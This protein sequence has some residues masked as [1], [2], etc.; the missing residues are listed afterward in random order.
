MA[1]PGPT[2]RAEA[3]TPTWAVPEAA[4][5][6]ALVGGFAATW[7]GAMTGVPGVAALLAGAFA[8]FYQAALHR[9]NAHGAAGMAAGAA[10]LGA[11]VGAIGLVLEL[12]PGGAA[13]ALPLAETYVTQAIEPLY[14]ADYAGRPPS[15]AGGPGQ[16]LAAVVVLAVAL[17]SARATRSLVPLL[18]AALVAGW[19]GI[20]GATA[21]AVATPGETH[22]LLSLHSVPPWAL[23]QLVGVVLTASVLS[24]GA[25]V[26]PLA[27]LDRPRRR[28]LAVGAPALLLGLVLQPLIAAPWGAWVSSA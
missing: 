1:E 2:W 23:L 14:R 6:L 21:A 25:P 12:G 15:G 10:I 18:A 20:A 11:L 8:T 3:P 7:A 27:E 13:R 26:F 4:W 28:L 17:A 5:F 22:V 19:L 9:R 16:L 24:S